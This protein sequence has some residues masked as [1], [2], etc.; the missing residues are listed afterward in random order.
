[1]QIMNFSKTNFVY[2]LSVLKCCAF[3]NL[4]RAFI[5]LVNTPNQLMPVFRTV[6]KVE[7]FNQDFRQGIRCDTGTIFQL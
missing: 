1:M 3:K 2:V 5:L 6:L 4:P 7:Q